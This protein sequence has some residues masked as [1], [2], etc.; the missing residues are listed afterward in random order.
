MLDARRLVGGAF[1]FEDAE[2]GTR[3]G[4]AEI[5]SR[6]LA[7]IVVGD[8]RVERGA[9]VCCGGNPVT[10]LVMVDKRGRAAVA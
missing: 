6:R 2:L 4:S 8:V 10:T 9:D 3:F 5:G 7:L 1:N